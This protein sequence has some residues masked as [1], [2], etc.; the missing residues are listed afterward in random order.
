[1]VP[2]GASNGF[3]VARRAAAASVIASLVLT[4]IGS[5]P[6]SA[7]TLAR[8]EGTGMP[9]LVAAPTTRAER[10]QIEWIDVDASHAWARTAID[11]GAGTR[12]WMRDFRSGDDGSLRFRPDAFAKRKHVARAIVRAFASGAQADGSITFPDLDASSRFFPS[13]NVAVSRGWFETRPDGSFDPEAPVTTSEL[14]RALVFARGLRP[15]ARALN[16]IRSADG[17]RFDVA[18][19]FGTNVLALRMNLRYPSRAEE[20]DVLPRTPLTRIQVAYS[21]HRAALLSSGTIAY[22]ADQYRDVTLPNMRDARR[23]IVEWGARFAGY[24]YIYGGEWGLG[25]RSPLGGQS[26]AGF[27][28]SGLIWW[29]VRRNDGA[30]SVAPPRPYRGWALPERSSAGMADA[31]PERVRYDDL[32]P[33][34]LMFYDGDGDGVIDHANVFVGRG[35]ALDS[36]TSTAGVT[37]MPVDEGWY[38]ENFRFGRRV[39]R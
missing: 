38:R 36:S 13:A 18:P 19:T 20:Y 8:S 2:G 27:D 4:L 3:V 32:Q 1:M 15:A 35:W 29:L 11:Y 39:G 26:M 6:L 37:L 21:L 10:S 33:G 17:E 30:W 9:A 34:D 24:P 23:E 14:H 16:D 28:C 7:G 31:A 22:L 12:R 25:S 5:P